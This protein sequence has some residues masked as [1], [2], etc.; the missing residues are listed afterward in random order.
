MVQKQIDCDSY[1]TQLNPIFADL[2]AK[3]FK[4][5][6]LNPVLH[7]FVLP[8]LLHK[9]Q[10]PFTLFELFSQAVY[11][12][13][14]VSC[15][16]FNIILLNVMINY[17]M[18]ETL[19]FSIL[20]QKRNIL[21]EINY[22]LPASKEKR[23]VSN[24]PI[25]INFDYLCRLLEPMGK[26]LEEA[27]VKWCHKSILHHDKICVGEIMNLGLSM[28]DNNPECYMKFISRINL[29]RHEG[30]EPRVIENKITT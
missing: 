22:K 1:R 11:L 15:Q 12:Y 30:D 3:D 28:G 24:F 9:L 10:K 2:Y 14:L 21:I 20:R 6:R 19:K 8:I 29:W 27:K 25:S 26:L 17:V 5:S 16:D 23:I 18:F 7:E 4:R 13:A